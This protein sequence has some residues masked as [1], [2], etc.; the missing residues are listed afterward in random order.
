MDEEKRT[1]LC[2]GMA[3]GLPLFRKAM[4]VTQEQ[5]A[6]IAGVTRNTVTHIERSKKMGWPTFLGYLMIFTR[7]E[8]TRRLVE[9]LGLCPAEL[10]AFLCGRTGAKE[11]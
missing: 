7:N 9:A 5:F 10:D 6:H 1:A 2:T 4:G 3:A 8:S 11:D